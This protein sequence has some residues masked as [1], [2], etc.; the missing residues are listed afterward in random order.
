MPL[1]DQS[2]KP[3]RPPKQPADV[4]RRAQIL[5]IATDLFGRQGISATTMASIA[6]EAQ[7][8]PALMHYYFGSRD[9]LLNALVS[10]RL[11]PVVAE[12]GMKVVDA[13]DDMR[14]LVRSFVR[15]M[16]DA[17]D[18]RPWFPPLWVREVLSDGGKLRGPLIDGMGVAL[19]V[20]LRDRFAAEQAKG[21]LN[22]DLDP[23]LLVVTLISLTLFPF[24][25]QSIWRTRLGATHVSS[26]TITTHALALLERGLEIPA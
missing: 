10:E 12:V 5:D 9:K 25:S 8:T 17:V 22:R 7:I 14:D 20:P 15:A 18:S 19:I 6:R 23:N 24:A 13:G 11:R 16:I 21:R 3:G 4:D 2:R 1:S 26:D